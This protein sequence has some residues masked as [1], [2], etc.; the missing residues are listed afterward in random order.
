MRLSFIT[1][2]TISKQ[3][4]SARV[5]LRRLPYALFLGCLIWLG[6]TIWQANRPIHNLK[7]VGHLDYFSEQEIK[8]FVKN[9]LVVKKNYL[10]CTTTLTLKQKPELIKAINLIKQRDTL[11]IDVVE[12]KLV[13]LWG[14]E[15]VLTSEA[16]LVTQKKATIKQLDFSKLPVFIGP[17]AKRKIM[18]AKLLTAQAMFPQ[19][20][21]LKIKTIELS[22]FGEWQLSLTNGLVLKLG[23]TEFAARLQRFIKVYP[24]LETDKI[25]KMSCVDLRYNNGLAVAWKS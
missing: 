15:G 5:I 21:S 16:K 10:I 2:N 9:N 17:T 7:V 1:Q 8:N 25:P 12:H 6:N 3:V 4:V 23:T 18:I 11:I 24:K 14:K 13:G 20:L 19:A 22:E